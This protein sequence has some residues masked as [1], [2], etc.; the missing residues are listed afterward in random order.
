MLNAMITE[1]ATKTTINTLIRRTFF[2]SSIFFMQVEPRKSMV[3]V[4][5]EVRTREER[6][7]IEAERTRTIT[8]PRSASERVESICGIMIS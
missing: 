1:I 3:S 8:T 4:E 6:V 2:F 7:D 5:L